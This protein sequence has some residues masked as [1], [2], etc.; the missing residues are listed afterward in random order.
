MMT[1][2]MWV[3]CICVDQ[4]KGTLEVVTVQY[5]LRCGFRDCCEV[6]AVSVLRGVQ[7]GATLRS[8][9]VV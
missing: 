4:G 1:R 8:A 3:G 7:G 9:I 2:V 6:A 5:C